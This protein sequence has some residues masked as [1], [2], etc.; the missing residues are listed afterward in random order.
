MSDD[1]LDSTE[2]Y[3]NEL[4]NNAEDRIDAIESKM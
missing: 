1:K 2:E 3:Y 4:I